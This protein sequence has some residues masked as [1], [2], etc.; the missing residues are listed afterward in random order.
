MILHPLT[1]AGLGEKN[2]LYVCSPHC[3]FPCTL[4]WMHFTNTLPAF[5]W[6]DGPCV[7]SK[8]PRLQIVHWPHRK[9]HVW[10]WVRYVWGLAMNMLKFSLRWMLQH[11]FLS[12]LL[13]KFIVLLRVLLYISGNAHFVKIYKAYC[14]YFSRYLIDRKKRRGM[15]N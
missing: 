5:Y 12:H 14:A 8:S 13:F 7:L 10:L 15:D 3:A 9:S 1:A 4:V 2:L 6:D 11:N